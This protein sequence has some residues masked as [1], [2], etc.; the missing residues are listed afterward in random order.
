MHHRKITA[1][2]IL[3][4]FFLFFA[5]TFTQTDRDH[6]FRKVI[7]MASTVCFCLGAAM[8]EDK[9]DETRDKDVPL[10]L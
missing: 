8:R 2:L 6:F 3:P 9:E 10:I 4:A 1:A 5:I 7:K